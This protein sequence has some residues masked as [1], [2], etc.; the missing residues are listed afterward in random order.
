MA[1][2]IAPTAATDVKLNAQILERLGFFFCRAGWFG[3]SS[4]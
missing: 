2:Q 1:A 3:L 4:A